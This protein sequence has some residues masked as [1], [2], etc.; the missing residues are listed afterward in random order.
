MTRVVVHI[1]SL[2]LRGIDP[3]DAPAL[4]AGIEAQLQQLLGEP[5]RAT[6]LAAAG[7]R[8]RVDA[9]VV[10]SSNA[11]SARQLGGCAARQIVKGV[12]P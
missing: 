9:G 4:S 10:D 7:N 12:M 6:R 2:I 5:G 1:D 8:R 3:A 11:K